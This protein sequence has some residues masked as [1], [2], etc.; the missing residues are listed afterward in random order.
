MKVRFDCDFFTAVRN[1]TGSISISADVSTMLDSSGLLLAIAK[2]VGA[3]HAKRILEIELKEQEAQEEKTIKNHPLSPAALEKFLIPPTKIIET[4]IPT[5]ALEIYKQGIRDSI[6][7][8]IGWHETVGHFV[9]QTV[10]QGPILI[11]SEK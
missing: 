10:G 2:Q 11:W 1:D 3:S 5:K 6:P 8:G 4:K 9:L 7:T